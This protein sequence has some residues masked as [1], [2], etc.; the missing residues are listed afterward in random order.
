MSLPERLATELD[1]L[2]RREQRDKRLPSVAA[3]VVRDGEK[4]WETAVGAADVDAKRDAT[5]EMQYRVGS[6]TKTFTA[7]AV[8]QLRDAGKLGLDDT[9]DLHIAGAAHAPTI[10]RLLS[11]TSGMQRETQD[12]AWL[13]LRFAPAEELVATLADAEQVL[14]AG[15]R[16]HYSNLAFALLGVVVERASGVPYAEYV[17]TRI[18]EPLGLRR[19]TFEPEE[20]AAVGY[21][22]DAFREGAVRESGVETGGWISAGQMWGT[23]GDLCRWAAF[24]ASPDESVLARATVEEMRTVQ[25]IA[26][27]DRWTSGYGLGLG[28][29]RDGER[30][31]AGHGGSMPG[32]I[33]SLLVSPSDGIGAAVLTN[34]SEADVEPLAAQLIAR[35]VA[36]WP[37]PPEPWRVEEPPPADVESMLGIWWIE[38]TQMSVRWRDGKLEGRFAGI[39]DWRPSSVFEREDGDRWRTVSGPEQGEILRVERAPDGTAARLIW[40]GY[41]VT[42]EQRPMA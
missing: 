5:P 32:F 29:R 9:L 34:S 28:L 25:T 42:R 41:P 39:P 2:V 17:R 33:A 1:G 38:G 30:I 36:A 24:L 18:L 40:A 31:L 8:M 12:D 15:A 4:V 37:V 35:T 16:F 10:R 11:H 26:D 23:V 27:H 22:V 14:P 20:P 19:I 6:I 3:A 21:L 7:A 13:T